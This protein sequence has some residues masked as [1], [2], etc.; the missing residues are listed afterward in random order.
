M[1]IPNELATKSA[2][3]CNEQIGVLLHVPSLEARAGGPS[4]TV[5]GLGDHLPKNGIR[6]VIKS[7]D[8]EG[9]Q[10]LILP[11]NTSVQ[12]QGAGKNAG[13]NTV[14]KRLAHHRKEV[15]DLCAEANVQIVHDNGLW[16]PQ[17]RSCY[18]AARDLGLPYILSTRGMLEPW[19]LSHKRWKKRVARILYQNEILQNT[20]V[21]HATSNE[22]ATAIR[23]LGYKQ[24]IAI[25]PNGIEFPSARILKSKKLKMPRRVLFISRIHKKKGLENLIKA[26]A[27]VRPK[28]WEVVIAGPEEGTHAND[29]RA[30]LSKLGLVDCFKFVGE[31]GGDQKTDLFNSAELFVLPSFSENF[32]VVVAES[33]A[34]GVPVIT[35]EQTPWHAL[36][37]HRSGWWIEN[38]VRSLA[39][40]LRE[41]TDMTPQQL[42]NMGRR[43]RRQAKEFLWPNIALEISKV[44][45]WATHGGPVPKCV[46]LD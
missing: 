29:L 36:S 17:N 7:S 5:T 2:S 13:E 27:E 35:T 39:A 3:V 22:E 21:F 16:L 14:F 4:R 37:E 30:M 31:V 15:S 1:V 25:Q 40:T 18:L 26:W 24:P 10:N 42:E 32:G 6:V 9:G 43:G 20:A 23:E 41:A 28:Q 11:A 46:R 12:V 8:I 44:Y 45:K 34:H 33:L 19:S 38:T